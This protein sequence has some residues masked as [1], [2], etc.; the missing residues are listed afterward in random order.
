MKLGVKIFLKKYF[1][2]KVSSRTAVFYGIIYASQIRRFQLLEEVICMK[3][4]TKKAT[5]ASQRFIK[6]MKKIA[7]YNK[8]HDPL[9]DIPEVYDVP[10]RSFI[11]FGCDL[12]FP[13]GPP[14]G[15]DG[16]GAVF[17]GSG[18][19][20]SRCFCIPTLWQWK[21]VIV[22]TDVKGELSTWHKQLRRLKYVERPELIFDPEDEQ[23][24]H[25]DPYA[26]I[27]QFPDDKH[28]IISLLVMTLIPVSQSASSEPSF[29]IDTSRNFLKA[30]LLYFYNQKISFMEAV[31]AIQTTPVSELL[32]HIKTDDIEASAYLSQSIEKHPPLI[33]SVDVDIHNALEVFNDP[34]IARAFDSTSASENDLLTWDKIDEYDVFLKISMD[35]IKSWKS[36]FNILYTQLI[37]CLNKRKDKYSG[38]KNNAQTLL[39][40][41]EFARF[42]RLPNF[43]DDISTLRSKSVNIFIVLQS[44]AQLDRIYG[45]DGRKEIMDN[46]NHKVIFGCNDADT[47]RYFADLIGTRKVLKASLSTSLDCDREMSSISIEEVRVNIIEPHELGDLGDDVIVISNGHPYRL[48]KTSMPNDLYR[49]YEEV[50][51]TE[52]SVVFTAQVNDSRRNYD[53]NNK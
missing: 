39:L 24:P 51:F 41:D 18:M 10:S 31:K 30:A 53:G 11:P 26:L 16:H 48:Q 40:M 52:D 14:E 23:C 50:T 38:G 36:A 17:G 20:K 46:C 45:V 47:R 3:K 1:N 9:D 13:I 34:R 4:I 32:N 49:K 21:G 8:E 29:W 28:A 27:D 12:V 2:V 42:G 25:Y 37:F 6:A 19:G 5:K 43:E 33:T 22:C 44:I 35:N 15:D 7:K